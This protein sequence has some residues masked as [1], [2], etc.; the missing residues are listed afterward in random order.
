MIQNFLVRII[1][2]KISSFSSEDK[3]KLASQSMVGIELVKRLVWN[4]LVFSGSSDIPTLSHYFVCLHLKHRKWEPK[5]VH[6]WQTE[7]CNR[8]LRPKAAVAKLY[9][10]GKGVHTQQTVGITRC[11]NNVLDPFFR[12]LV[13]PMHLSLWGYILQ[14]S[15]CASC[16]K[17]K[18]TL[19]LSSTPQFQFCLVLH[20]IQIT[21]TQICRTQQQ[22]LSQSYT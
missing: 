22:A 14:S 15:F 19:T 2:K 21:R 16:Y 5:G 9:T 12:S 6:A 20:Q 13:F 1:R 8:Y 17:Y 18:T 3:L 4:Q 7:G 10:H 11:R